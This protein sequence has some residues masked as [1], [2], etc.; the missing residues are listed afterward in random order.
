MIAPV[1]LSLTPHQEE[2]LTLLGRFCAASRRGAIDVHKAPTINAGTMA[3]LLRM[4]LTCSA[5]V[6]PPGGSQ[7]TVYWLTEEGNEISARLRREAAQRR[8]AS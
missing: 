3:K 8:S 4:G 5:V 7:R 1:P 2:Q 6:K